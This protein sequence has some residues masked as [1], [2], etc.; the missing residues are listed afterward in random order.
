LTS[1][2]FQERNYRKKKIE[3]QKENGKGKEK[4]KEKKKNKIII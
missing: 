4:R 2:K 1:P 3:D